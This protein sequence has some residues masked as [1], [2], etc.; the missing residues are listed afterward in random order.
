[1]RELQTVAEVVETLGGNPAV[2]GLTGK[3]GD[4][5][6]SNWKKRG[7]F[8][9]ATYAILKSAL[10]AHN[11]TAPDSLWRMAGEAHV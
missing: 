9:P 11:A 10:E 2:A 5:A 1:M 7:S 8:P 6:V 4:S 3:K